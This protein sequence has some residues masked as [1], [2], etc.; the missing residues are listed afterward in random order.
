MDEAV[1]TRIQ[2]ILDAHS[3]VLFMKGTQ[4]FPQCGFSHRAVEILKRCGAKEMHTV[5]VLEDPEIRQGI[6]D[7]GNWPTIPQLYLKGKL[8]GGSDILMEMFESGELQPMVE[9][10]QK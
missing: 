10:A 4:H 9:D 1:K 5:N 7:F 3:V 8:V 6:K 2:S